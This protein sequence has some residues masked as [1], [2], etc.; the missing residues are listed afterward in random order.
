MTEKVSYR[1]Q[2][3]HGW[4][5]SKAAKEQAAKEHR[6]VRTVA[7]IKALGAGEWN[8]TLAVDIWDDAA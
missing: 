1:V 5:A 6:R 8:V 4:Q 2:A 3:I 7:S